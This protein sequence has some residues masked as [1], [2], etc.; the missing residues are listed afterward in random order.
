MIKAVMAVVEYM[1]SL[2]LS[3]EEQ[4]RLLGSVSRIN[5][6]AVA[7]KNLLYTEGLTEEEQAQAIR[8]IRALIR[9]RKPAKGTKGTKDKA[10]A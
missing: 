2:G 8:A 4:L 9:P 6:D 10:K 7:V 1:E 5:P 3:T